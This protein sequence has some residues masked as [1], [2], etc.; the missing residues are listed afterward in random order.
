MPGLVKQ[1]ASILAAVAVVTLAAGCGGS[2]G[3]GA[4]AAAPSASTKTT[5]PGVYKGTITSTATGVTTPV[6]AMVGSAGEAAWMSA[7]GRVWSGTMPTTGAHFDVSMMGRMYPGASFPDGSTNATWMMNVDH[8]QTQMSGR[9]TGAGDSG[10]F[11]LMLESMS[12]RPA[13]LATLA[14][15][16]TRSTWS[17][18]AMTMTIGSGG[19]LIANDSRGCMI[20][21]MVTVPDASRNL[22]SIAATVS[23]CGVLDGAYR[24][25]GSLQDADAMRDWMA[26]MHPLEQGGYSHGNMDMSGMGHMGGGMGG[27][28]YNAVPSGTSN[29]FMFV[30]DDGHHGIMDALAR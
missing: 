11:S 27:M 6:L 20:N 19:D 15:V 26:A 13:S 7:D 25:V 10:T 30:L 5:T 16:Y 2:G 24:G 23:S 12:G 1:P 21:G 14:G 8:V 29:L 18:Y 22:Y 17:G 28:T 4:S 9:Y 3:S